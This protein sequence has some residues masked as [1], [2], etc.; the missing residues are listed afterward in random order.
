MLLAQPVHGHPR[1][2]QAARAFADVE[3][4]VAQRGQY[5]LAFGQYALAI[6]ASAAVV[7]RG[8]LMA[9][10]VVQRVLDAV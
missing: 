8:R 4:G 2:A 7:G 1:H 6:Q 5:R 10:S 9:A 3:A